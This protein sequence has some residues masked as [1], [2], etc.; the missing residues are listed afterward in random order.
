MDIPGGGLATNF[1]PWESP[2]GGS[3]FLGNRQPDGK[4][5]FIPYTSGYGRAYPA[6]PGRV[7]VTWKNPY[8]YTIYMVD[9]SGQP[10][11]RIGARWTVEALEPTWVVE[12]SGSSRG[13]IL[14]ASEN[15]WRQDI[16]DGKIL[17]R[18]LA[19]EVSA[20]RPFLETLQVAYDPRITLGSVINLRDPDVYGVDFNCLVRGIRETGTASGPE[21]TLSVQP[22]RTLLG[23]I[24]DR[25]DGFT[26]GDFD[27]FYTGKTL[28]SADN[29]PLGGN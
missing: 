1:I 15:P 16:N 28:G 23:Q 26:L 9:A 6:G 27:A 11:M 4:G 10:A 5:D 24:D 13:G 29:N 12:S 17:A 2:T 18:W 22:L 14:V 19:E 25:W 20:P 8:A 21:M 7:R 3:W